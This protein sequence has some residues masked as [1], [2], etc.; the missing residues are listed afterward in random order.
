MES[1]SEELTRRL[2]WLKQ[3][4][5]LTKPLATEEKLEQSAILIVTSHGVT[6]ETVL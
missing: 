5:R 3:A 6:L 2:P 4:T 1:I